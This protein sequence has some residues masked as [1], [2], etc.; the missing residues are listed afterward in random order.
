MK[1]LFFICLLILSIGCSTFKGEIPIELKDKGVFYISP[2]NIDG[3]FDEFITPV[4]V[5]PVKGLK[6]KGY[7]ITLVSSFGMEIFTKS[8]GKG[9]SE[10]V[11]FFSGISKVSLPVNLKWDGKNSMGEFVPDGLYLLNVEVWDSK[12]NTGRIEPFKIV[13]DNTYP[14][15]E[16]TIPYNSFSPNTENGLKFITIY[17]DSSSE[18]KWTGK[19][20][21][22]NGNI[23]SE[24]EWPGIVSNL[25]LDGLDNSGK[26]LPD[27]LYKYTLEA[28]DLAGN[29]FIT[30]I[31]NIEIDRSEPE[32]YFNSPELF[33][34]PNGDGVKD[35]VS[36]TLDSTN[37]VKL[38]SGFIDIVNSKG[39]V[40]KKITPINFTLPLSFNFDGLVM[41]N[42]PLP[43]DTYYANFKGRFTN[44]NV[45]EAISKKIHIDLSKPETVLSANYLIFS[46]EG[47]GLQDTILINQSTSPENIWIGEIVDSNNRSIIQKEWTER[48]ISFEWD[49]RDINNV[50]V[51]DGSY[52]YILSCEDLAGN[53]NKFSLGP[54]VID[55]TD[56]KAYISVSK[57]SFSPNN[58]GIDDYIDFKPSV[59]VLNGIKDWV[60]NIR[61]S[62]DNVIHSFSGLTTIPE[63]LSWFGENIDTEKLDGKYIAELQVSYLKGNI[64][65]A[66]INTSFTI[67]LEAPNVE[68]AISPNQFSPDSDGVD[69]ILS[70]KVKA[71][72]GHNKFSIA[73]EIQDPYGRKFRTLK[74][75]DFTNNE[76][77]WDGKA[78]DGELVQSATDYSLII[79]AID[80]VG[81]ISK[82][83]K[84][85]PVDILVIKDGDKL[86][87]VISSIYFKPYTADFVNVEPDILAKNLQT[88]DRLSEILKKYSAYNINL[89]GNA[90][91]IYWEDKKKWLNEEKEILL[92]LSEQRAQVI[93]DSLI[94]KG[95]KA[96]RM[97]TQGLGGY[98]PVV[99]HSDLD[100]RW[101]NRRVEFVLIK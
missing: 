5:P 58:D 31:D 50:D 2:K 35:S 69:D 95:V 77:L 3:V 45:A 20:L 32:L 41:N 19:L 80:S 18:E 30:S 60:L 87:I 96:S 38:Q 15:S 101:K 88:L 99:P 94:A 13:V 48:A 26:I 52:R 89:E 74:I 47:D 11:S 98:N 8:G 66:A 72:D 1:K 56:T 100:N 63:K 97:T 75:D 33:I 23:V 67:D 24:Y 16:I 53:S 17:Q 91:R 61:D 12:G 93:R 7:K 76:F 70:I 37:G 14:K 82:T 43:E 49:G 27:G 10:K 54:F 34:S 22:A 86:R 40:V 62:S 90:V 44:G 59:S 51:P 28:T 25:E 85:I 84:D 73:G 64:A 57:N 55:R 29:S 81:N 42:I 68:I 83:E 36:L 39:E 79:T 4:R 78:D 9:I 71:S 6:I 65:K 92:A 46:P 21:D